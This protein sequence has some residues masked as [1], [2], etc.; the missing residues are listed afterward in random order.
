MQDDELARLDAS[1]RIGCFVV[2]GP[3][4]KWVPGQVTPPVKTCD[5]P[6]TY[7]MTCRQCAR[8]I[9]LCGTHAAVFRNDP[10]TY[11]HP[12][13][14]SGTWAVMMEFRQLGMKP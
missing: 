5:R 3:P 13:G 7:T 2:A 9:T 4:P 12:C 8:G 10:H 1:V 14:A 11:Y 6:A